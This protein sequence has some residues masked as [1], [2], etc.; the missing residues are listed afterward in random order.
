MAVVVSLAAVAGIGTAGY[1]QLNSKIRTFSSAG[2]S[3]KRPESPS[4]GSQNILLIGSDTRSGDNTRLGGA[5]DAVGRSDTTLVVHIY[6]DHKRAVAVSIP[7]DS[8]V[9]IPRCRLPDGR[10]TA[11]QHNVMF[12]SAF[13]VGLSPEGNPACTLNTVEE[14][15]GLKIDHTVIA[16]FSGFAALS[17]AVGGVPVCLP[18]PVYQ[19]DL[20]PNRTDQGRMIFREGVQRVSGAK[21]L[22]YVRIRHGIG[23]GSDLGRIDRQQAFLS[24]LI[25]TI[26]HKGL[27]TQ[28]LL[29]LVNAATENLTFDPSLSSTASLLSFAISLRNFDPSQVQFVTVPWAYEGARVR[30]VQPDANRLFSALRANQPI[31][32]GRPR[33]VKRASASKKH[34]AAEETTD[35]PVSVYNGSLR[36]GLAART[37]RRL[38]K[39][40]Y[41]IGTIANADRS[42]YRQTLV[43][44]GPGEAAE[45]RAVARHLHARLQLSQRPGVRVVIGREY[46]WTDR[47]ADHTPLPPSVTRNVRSADSDPCSHVTYG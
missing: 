22:Q 27:T 7:R 33:H 26:R 47:G 8:L 35:S 6:P 34:A 4:E 30:I 28:H 5:G 1:M 14:L 31:D 36:S 25:M 10:W 45:A 43:E 39:L 13:S 3:H 42:N 9:T 23:D 2:I 15:T 16:N 38:E 19:A 12:N 29:P 11:P 18:N 40:G 41:E 20:N 46:T 37:A 32:A 24:S 17:K 21:A 44:Y